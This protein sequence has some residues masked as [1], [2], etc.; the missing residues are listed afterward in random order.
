MTELPEK[1]AMRRS[2]T[3]SSVRHARILE[4]LH[5]HGS[6][7]V[8]DVASSVN[9]SD[10]T[11][12]RDFLELEANAQLVRVHGG[13]VL[14]SNNLAREGEPEPDFEWRLREN[15]DAKRRIAAAAAGLLAGHRTIAIDVGTS[16]LLLA[17]QLTGAANVKF[18]TNS[19]RVATE[20]TAPTREVYLAGGKVRAGELAV[21]GPSAA[22]D[23][24]NLWFDVA[25]IGASSITP[26]GLYDYSLEDIEI[27]R[28]YVQRATQKI[29]L[30]DSSKFLHRSLSKIC[31][32]NEVD[33]LV[34]DAQPPAEL[35][36]ALTDAKVK[37]V[38]A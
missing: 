21:S 1:R 23:F 6:L 22:A 10:M 18:F 25:V 38:I 19:L 34:T 16:T 15:L 14:P 7:L 3:P 35:A 9:V 13:A 20:L 29:V 30:C 11:I 26:S 31:A 24:S 4:L 12:R 2:R 27:K 36:S 17:R 37:T 5:E 33:T 32:L 28:V 8:S